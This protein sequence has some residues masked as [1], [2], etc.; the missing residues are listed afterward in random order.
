VEGR[1]PVKY[2]VRTTHMNGA[3]VEDH[4]LWAYSAEDAVFQLETW[5]GKPRFHSI[6]YVGPVNPDC[7]CLNECR[8][9]VQAQ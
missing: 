9:G 5:M 8:C 4:R 1:H 3:P 2:L 7:K 6:I